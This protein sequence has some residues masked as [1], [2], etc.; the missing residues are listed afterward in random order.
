MLEENDV[1]YRYREYTDE[2]LDEAEIRRVLELLGVGPKAVLRKDDR[3]ARELA[4]TGEE[5]DDTLIAHMA[6]HPTL[7]QRPIGVLGNR[8]V[9]GRP[10]AKLLELVYPPQ[11][12]ESPAR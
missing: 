1:A 10:P 11:S 6:G 7:L 12:P 2:P 5:D 3:A 4:L 9:V 8:A